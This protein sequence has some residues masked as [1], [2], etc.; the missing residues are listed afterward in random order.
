MRLNRLKNTNSLVVRKKISTQERDT[1]VDITTSMHNQSSRITG[2]NRVEWEISKQLFSRMDGKTKALCWV[3][4]QQG[5]VELPDGLD[6][7]SIY[8]FRADMRTIPDK[9]GS[10]ARPKVGS[11]IVVAGSAWMQNS[12]YTDSVVR[13]VEAN[14][15]VLT[16]VVY[17]L[18]PI[19]FPQWYVKGYSAVFERN[20][21]ELCARA[22]N[23]MC[24]SNSTVNDL[25][26]FLG[27]QSD[28][29]IGILPLG[30][31]LDVSMNNA[32]MSRLE[33]VGLK[34]KPLLVDGVPSRPFVLAVGSVHPRK[35]YQLLY[36]IWNEAASC[37]DQKLPDL[38]IVGGYG[39]HS[40]ELKHAI[41][42]AP[43][44]A[45]SWHVLTGVDDEQL[46]ELYRQCM[47]TV[48][49]SLYEG[50]GLPVAES[51]AFGKPCICSNRSSI[52]EVAPKELL[53]SLDPLDFQSWRSQITA[54]IRN[55]AT[56]EALM[57]RIKEKFRQ[58]EWSDSGA[59][60]QNKLLNSSPKNLRPLIYDQQLVLF[61]NTKDSCY[62]IFGIGWAKPETDGVFTNSNSADI[63]WNPNKCLKGKAGVWI[64]YSAYLPR[65][66]VKQRIAV[67]QDGKSI[68]S[69]TVTTS[70]RQTRFVPI[71]PSTG[72]LQFCH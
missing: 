30:L 12:R 29:R 7:S 26:Q 16:I 35:N 62:G 36:N 63:H 65:S 39:W 5:F 43:T 58:I 14:D 66:Q 17:D 51:L 50:W 18:V 52:P 20:L 61:N 69:W 68:D 38:V 67:I 49:P 47:F 42:S 25:K 72:F 1:W 4:I 22:S 55:R 57:V 15:M 64:Q 46:S 10:P 13:L 24:I 34:S 54:M 59:V 70:H 6:D 11:N 45:C 44:T 40:D 41:E 3:G 21:S 60:L 56:R 8:R 23:I 53:V 28:E 33:S 27:A 31:S 19:L 9:F 48:Y 2:I 71:D 37:S 32:E